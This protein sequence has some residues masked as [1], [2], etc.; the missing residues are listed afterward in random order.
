MRLQFSPDEIAQNMVRGKRSACGGGGGGGLSAEGGQGLRL[1][2]A[3]AAGLTMFG[4][5]LSN[6][7]GVRAGASNQV[8][9]GKGERSGWGRS[10]GT[11]AEGV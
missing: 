11:V 3:G 7:Q 10:M 6:A 2:G 4:R 5:D 8:I 1:T 9:E